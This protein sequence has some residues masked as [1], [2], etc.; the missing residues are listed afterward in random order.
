MPLPSRAFSHTRGHL[1]VSRASLDGLRKKETARSLLLQ[2]KTW[3]PLW[4]RDFSYSS[5]DSFTK[6]EQICKLHFL[7]F[8]PLACTF[9]LHFSNFDMYWQRRPGKTPHRD[10][11]R[12]KPRTVKPSLVQS[13]VHCFLSGLIRSCLFVTYRKPETAGK[14]S[15]KVTP[16]GTLETF[17][18]VPRVLSYSLRRAGRREP[19]ERGWETFRF[20]DEN[21]YEYEIWFK[22]F[23]RIVKKLISR[24]ASFYFFHQKS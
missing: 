2:S 11:A 10:S 22:V 23:S 19:W 20:E 13:L 21:D 8:F 24:N 16:S 15:K 9:P 12:C 4:Y 17:N 6:T 7:A 3:V 18:L 14:R 1:R 5:F